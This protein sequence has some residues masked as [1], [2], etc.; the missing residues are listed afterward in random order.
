MDNCIEF[1]GYKDKDGYGRKRSDG[2]MR[3]AHRLAYCESKNIDIKE[4]DG[5][6][7]MHTC[8]NPPCINPE[9]LKLGT[10][11]DNVDDKM[12]KGRHAYNPNTKGD[13]HGRAK[14]TS[15]DVFKIREMVKFKTQREVGNIFGISNQQVSGIVRREY[16]AHLPE[17]PSID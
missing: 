14:I 10:A 11:Q 7:V 16:W 4:I 5:L 1:Q 2:K 9:H 15:E 3:F 8:D 13:A 6:V 12:K 17:Q